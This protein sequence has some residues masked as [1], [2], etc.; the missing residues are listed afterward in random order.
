MTSFMTYYQV[1]IYAGVP[2][3]VGWD[4]Y[5]SVTNINCLNLKAENDH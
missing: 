5:L 1:S 3:E 4:A 2:L